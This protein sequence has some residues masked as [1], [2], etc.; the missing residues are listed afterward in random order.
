MTEEY[1]PIEIDENLLEELYW[2]YLERSKT[3]SSDRD[4]FKGYMRLFARHELRRENG[5]LF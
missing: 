3:A 5:I 4:L 2:E 1:V